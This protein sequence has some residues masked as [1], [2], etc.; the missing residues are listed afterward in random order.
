MT[1]RLYPEHVAGLLVGL[2][3]AA[4]AINHGQQLHHQHREVLPAIPAATTG[5]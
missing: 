1:R 3:L 4:M 5:P 2:A